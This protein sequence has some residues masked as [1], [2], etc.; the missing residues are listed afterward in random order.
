VGLAVASALIVLLASGVAVSRLGS[1]RSGNGSSNTAGPTPETGAGASGPV[2]TNGSGPTPVD[3]SGALSSASAP[4]PPP[5]PAPGTARVRTSRSAKAPAAERDRAGTTTA[6]PVSTAASGQPATASN[7]GGT[8]AGSGGNTNGNEAPPSRQGAPETSAVTASASVGEGDS[9]GVVALGV[10]G[11]PHADVTLGTTQVFGDA[12][13][14]NGTGIG[15]GGSL[16]YPPP[17]I[18]ILPG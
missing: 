2:A 10:G 1:D 9:G 14:S 6:A 5:V 4:V 12:P 15:L 11:Q 7:S 18:P 8:T 3:T 17:T 16:L 13:P